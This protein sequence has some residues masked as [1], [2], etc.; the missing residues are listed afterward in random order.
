MTGPTILVGEPWLRST[1]RDPETLGALLDE[2]SDRA[3]DAEALVLDDP[4]RGGQTVRWTYADLRHESRRIAKSLVAVGLGKG[5]RVGLLMSNRPEAVA[6]IFGAGLVGA[7]AVPLSTFSPKPEL[8]YLVAHG[9]ISVLLVQTS[10]GSRTFAAD[11]VE[12]CPSAVDDAPTADPAFPFLRHVV[13]LGPAA[14]AAGLESWDQF[15]ARGQQVPDELLDAVVG[16]VDPFDPGVVIYSS[17][18]TSR[19]KGV[20]H[21]HA[22]ATR[23]A[24]MQAELFRRDTS[25]RLWCALPLFWTAGMNTAM[26][27]TIAGGGC[28]VLQEGFDAGEALALMARER[29]TEPH[30][31]PHQAKALQEHA[32]WETTD[33]SSCTKVFGK[34]VFT[35]HP[36]VEGDTTWN[37]PVGYGSSE[38]NSFI[39]GLD[40]ATPREVLAKGSY[41]RLLPGNEL[42]VVDPETGASLGP[43]QEGELVLRGP[44][45]MEHYVKRSRADSLDA[46]GWYHTGDFGSFDADGLVYFS[47]RRTEMIKTSGA[48]VSPAEIEVQLRAC[49]PVRLARVVGVDDERRD[50]IVVL[51]VELR[52]GAQATEDEIKAFLRERLASFKVPKRVVFFAAGEMPMTTSGTKVKQDDLLDLVRARL[53]DRTEVEA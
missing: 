30:T 38:M 13:A 16:N 14:D 21:H 24:R 27:A 39:T 15:L 22:S 5:A 52:D 1:D 19:P 37:T 32:D 40:W 11:V 45:L 25:T 49:E 48:N 10:M 35:K 41:G 33:L 23:Q 42:K 31:L 29:V 34:S 53:G 3:A 9:D 7:I 50:Q 4:L 47:G 6:G 2:V 20:L 8:A 17:G 44:T 36:T 43:G 28:W 51:C 26:G 12:L 18:T 46:D